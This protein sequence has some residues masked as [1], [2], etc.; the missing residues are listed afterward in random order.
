MHLKNSVKEIYLIRHGETDWN[1]KHVS[2]GQ[3]ADISLNDNGKEQAT[4]TG[5][6]LKKYRSSKPFDCIYA[7]PMMRAKETA[8]I[9]KNIIELNNDIIYDYRLKEAKLGKFSGIPKNDQLLKK[10]NEKLDNELPRDPIER[11]LSKDIINEKI[12]K[13]FDIGNESANDIEMRAFDIITEIVKSEFNK[14]LVVSHGNLL[15]SMMRKIFKIPMIP[16][17]NL[18]N[19]DNCYITLITYNDEN[20]F[21]M[22]TPPNTEHLGDF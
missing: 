8:E 14:I 5:L 3:E 10:Y 1:K 22:I 11:Y 17:G 6:Y 7:S 20:G 18:D 2:M 4:K 13:E 9:I 21:R 15:L 19:G 16:Q 12:S